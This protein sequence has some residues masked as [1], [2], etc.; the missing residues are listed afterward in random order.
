MTNSSGATEC[1]ECPPGTVSNVSRCE[2]C[3]VDAFE[4][5]NACWPCPANSSQP[6]PGSAVCV[7][8][9]PCFS[10]PAPN[11]CVFQDHDGDWVC[12]A[13]D[14]CPS[15][16]NA[17]Q[18]ASVNPPTGDACSFDLEIAMFFSKPTLVMGVPV[19]PANTTLDVVIEYNN[20]GPGVL[21]AQEA[22]VH[23][24]YT[25]AHFG[26]VNGG[27]PED[28]VPMYD[29][30][31]EVPGG[32]MRVSWAVQT[33]LSAA[34]LPIEIEV[35]LRAD[36]DVLDSDK[37]N[38][39]GSISLVPQ[40]HPS[41]LVD[42]FLE[43]NVA[44]IETD[45]IDLDEC[46]GVFNGGCEQLCID[47]E[48]NTGVLCDCSAGFYPVGELCFE[49]SRMFPSPASLS[50]SNASDGAAPFQACNGDQLPLLPGRVF[51]PW[52]AS[53]G[54][55]PA[56][57]F[58]TYPDRELIRFEA[59][60]G[61]VLT[62]GWSNLTSDA[63][64]LPRILPGGQD[65]GAVPLWT[66]TSWLGEPTDRTTCASNL[67]GAVGWTTLDFPFVF[68]LAAASGSLPPVAG[69]RW[70]D[71]RVD[72]PCA[73]DE[74]RVMCVEGVAASLSGDACVAGLDDCAIQAT[75]AP[76]ASGSLLFSCA[77]NPGFASPSMAAQP[78]RVCLPDL[79]LDG[80]AD[81]EDN[82][83]GVPNADQTPYGAAPF[84]TR[85]LACVSDLRVTKFG[86]ASGLIFAGSAIRFSLLVEVLQLGSQ[87]PVI[88]LEDVFENGA[89][90]A[91]LVLDPSIPPDSI[92]DLGDSTRLLWNLT[93]APNAT[94]MW[95]NYTL[96]TNYSAP[97]DELEISNRAEVFIPGLLFLDANPADN[98]DNFGRNLTQPVCLQTP[99]IC[100]FFGSC[101]PSAVAPFYKC[102]C[103]FGFRNVNQTF[104]TNWAP[105]DLQPGEGFRMMFVT[106]TK[107][108]HSDFNSVLATESD[109]LLCPLY[110]LIV[111]STT[112]PFFSFQGP[113][114][115]LAPPFVETVSVPDVN[116]W[117][118]FAGPDPANYRGIFNTL[119]E[120]VAADEDALLL[121][122]AD[123]LS[124]QIST[125][126]YEPIPTEIVAT[127]INNR[128]TAVGGYIGQATH[129]AGVS[130][131]RNISAFV[132]QVITSVGQQYRLYGV[133][134]ALVL[135]GCLPACAAPNSECAGTIVSGF[136]CVCS[137]G[138]Q[139]D[140]QLCSDVDEC[141]TPA[142]M[143]EPSVALCVNTVGSYECACQ[144]PFLPQTLPPLANCSCPLGQVRAGATCVDA[145]ECL[146]ENFGND[147]SANASCTNLPLGA[148]ALGLGFNCTCSAGFTDSIATATLPGRVCLADL[149]SDGVGDA[150]DNCPD[151]PNPAQTLFP[152]SALGDACASDLQVSVFGSGE[153]IPGGGRE[154][155]TI[156]L[157]ILATPYVLGH[158]MGDIL[159]TDVY[160]AEDLPGPTLNPAWGPT[161]PSTP[162]ATISA[163][164]Q[165]V[166]VTWLVAPG[167]L[168][169]DITY[170]LIFDTDTVNEDSLETTVSA[171][172]TQPND[173]LRFPDQN[174][175]NNLDS[176]L[177]NL[178]DR[179][180]CLAAPCAAPAEACV[181]TNGG[182]ACVCAPGR[183]D[184]SGTCVAIIP[185]PAVDGDSFRWLFITPGER[186]AVATQH[187]TYSS[188]VQAQFA[189]SLLWLTILDLQ[190]RGILTLNDAQPGGP[191]DDLHSQVVARA[192]NGP[193]YE[194]AIE[195]GVGLN[196]SDPSFIGIFNPRGQLLTTTTSGYSSSSTF[197]LSNSI[198]YTADLLTTA[199]N[200]VWTGFR[201]SNR[202]LGTT[203]GGNPRSTFGRGN[204]GVATSRPFAFNR[205]A[206]TNNHPLYG[207]T[208]VYQLSACAELNCAPTGS[209]CQGSFATGFQC[210]CLPSFTGDGNTCIPI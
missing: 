13:L 144:A 37:G 41:N 164:G 158:L 102:I 206:T 201:Q 183:V 203:S 120:F 151:E 54:F 88:A 95:V 7:C 92:Q 68:N 73:S 134:L 76:D 187:S 64:V 107:H 18:N 146:G 112:M 131:R 16:P 56:A 15:I 50:G 119:G 142:D 195:D 110:P 133:T 40:L 123:T 39:T 28:V 66:F 60:N 167:S 83:P 156:H 9:A 22:V 65:A 20:N 81:V 205:D 199:D 155:V 46:F 176:Y 84:P 44:G 72:L 127:G 98:S 139:G 26:D 171:A 80:V 17:D 162:P 63:S 135:Q 204:G 161:D 2:P 175:N 75:C 118:G 49:S 51:V 85:G 136:A 124:A 145:D 166:T 160:S 99:G 24:F 29:Q 78:G 178:T 143:C 55:S 115:Y 59:L 71:A 210:A 111:A 3:G 181:N 106:R 113:V 180:E 163:T 32:N 125:C 101:Y 82:C 48:G 130:N 184:L 14:N 34:D 150:E 21:P 200:D 12:D 172:L 104:C 79:D 209:E 77:C 108:V 74:P 5:G 25:R 4:S 132:G 128:P 52:L 197:F 57:A 190:N 147:C 140:G 114:T 35:R 62:V 100:Q 109:F 38:M 182:F 36:V 89:L 47:L 86:N 105:L 194:D 43:N 45:I 31:S 188:F 207:I 193:D 19:T 11:T 121:P 126:D 208:R 33:Q 116:T 169:L 202:R 42:Y 87:T 8:D 30:C 177:T 93:F 148:G 97:V 58:L 198:T 173:L 192:V 157:S 91:D 170:H 117:V 154:N 70:S 23:L 27:C 103:N 96:L 69:P 179:N 159:V 61:Q 90:V 122:G 153:D 53:G 185:D 191:P 67:T 6:Q 165:S 152:G 189:T 94:S 174:P 10:T 196:P 138:F 1:W 149:D 137:A 129:S 186:N 141:Q 168:P